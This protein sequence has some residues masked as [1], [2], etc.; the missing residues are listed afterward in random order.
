MFYAKGSLCFEHLNN[1]LYGGK[2]DNEYFSF[3]D[4]G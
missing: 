3:V 1:S 2:K 4:K